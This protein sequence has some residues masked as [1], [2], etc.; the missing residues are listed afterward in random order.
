MKHAKLLEVSAAVWLG[1][2]VING[3]SALSANNEAIKAKAIAT[4]FEAQGNPQAAEWQTTYADDKEDDRNRLL[5]LVAIDL[6]VVAITGVAVA[7]NAS[8][9][10]REQEPQSDTSISQLKPS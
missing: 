4:T 2:G 10:R 7:Y 8:S 9:R 6:G 5:R 1:I 3:A